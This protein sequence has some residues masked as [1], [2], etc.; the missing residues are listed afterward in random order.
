M[1]LP[2][3]GQISLNQV[4]TELELSPTSTVSM[5]NLNVRTLFG[6]P[7][8][9]IAMSNGYGKSHSFIFNKIISANIANYN[10]K[11]DAIASG[12]NQIVK[13][14]ATVTINPGIIV[15]SSSNLNPAFTTG[16]VFPSTSSISIINNGYIVGA[17][18][19][20]GS[21]GDVVAGG[22]NP[23]IT[24]G[25][26]G[27]SGGNA[28]GL[29]YNVSITNASGVIGGGGGGGGGGAAGKWGPNTSNAAGG[30]G[31]GGGAGGGMGGGGGFI[32]ASF[33]VAGLPGVSG[34]LTGGGRGGSGGSTTNSIGGAG[35]SGGE[36]GLSGANGGGGGVFFASAPGS[37]GLAGKAI[38]LNGFIANF[39]SGNDSARLKGV[40]S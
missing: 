17:G 30:G 33:Q 20:G 25:D 34:A 6:A 7:A 35:G 3:S 28:I 23:A 12:W 9:A 13:L 10:L 14:I 4:N 27:G 37:G 40:V 1:A 21:G 38:S 15:F 39:I 31:G 24:N 26:M 19:A 5:G 8:N 11:A 18:G 36:L 22:F 32:V 16:T 29:G 2:T